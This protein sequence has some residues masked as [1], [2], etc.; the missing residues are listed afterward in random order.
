TA[1]TLTTNVVEL[2]GQKI[3]LENWTGWADWWEASLDMGSGIT[4]GYVQ[5]VKFMTKERT[6]RGPV[7]R[8]SMP[9]VV[10]TG[11]KLLERIANGRRGARGKP[12]SVLGA[13]EFVLR[14]DNSRFEHLVG[15]LADLEGDHP[16][17][18]KGDPSHYWGEH[19]R[20]VAQTVFGAIIPDVHAE[21]RM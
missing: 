8:L 11:E 18:A 20:T 13:G 16:T 2:T 19:I 9:S 21:I 10:D 14:S 3:N 1:N 5:P 17:D 4:T 15:S 6:E 12:G 7:Y